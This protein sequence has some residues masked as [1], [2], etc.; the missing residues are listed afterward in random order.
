MPANPPVDVSRSQCTGI[1]TTPH[2][3][4]ECPPWCLLRTDHQHPY[5]PDEAPLLHMSAAVLV[6]IVIRETTVFDDQVLSSPRARECSVGLLRMQGETYLY[7]N[8]DDSRSLDL[9]LESARRLIAA[10]SSF[11]DAAE[12]S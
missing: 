8:A 5:P 2:A 9:T 1:M 4:D 3:F 6:P 12:V 11:L 10:L 7:C